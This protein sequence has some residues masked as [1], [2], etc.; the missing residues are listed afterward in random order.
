[1]G[2]VAADSLSASNAFL[3][4]EQANLAQQPFGPNVGRLPNGR[5][6]AAHGPAVVELAPARFI[7]V[8]LNYRLIVRVINSPEGLQEIHQFQNLLELYRDERNRV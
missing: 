6:V 8:P 4:G 1:M 5:I 2:G 3:P 7:L